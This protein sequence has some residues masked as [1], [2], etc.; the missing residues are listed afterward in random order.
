MDRREPC[1]RGGDGLTGTGVVAKF[2]SD[3]HTLLVSTQSRLVHRTALIGDSIGDDPVTDFAPVS[4]L[5]EHGDAGRASSVPA[6]RGKAIHGAGGE[7][8]AWKFVPA[9]SSG[10]PAVLTIWPAITSSAPP[11][12]EIADRAVPGHRGSRSRR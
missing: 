2:D 7:R 12:L 3:G 8:Q 10:R 11:A 1:R 9:A 6:R 4:L 5:R